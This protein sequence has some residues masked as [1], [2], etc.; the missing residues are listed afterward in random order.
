MSDPFCILKIGKN[1]GK[2]KTVKETLNP[3]WI[4]EMFIPCPDGK[5]RPTPAR[6]PVNR[7]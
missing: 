3:E 7:P 2:S 4:E 1:G 5:L 6:Q